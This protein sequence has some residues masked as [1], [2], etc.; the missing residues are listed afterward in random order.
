MT[1]KVL[2]P[3]CGEE[4]QIQGPFFH[5]KNYSGFFHCESCGWESPTG[6]GDTKKEAEENARQAALR[7]Y[8]PP[9]RPMTLEE[10]EADSY[11][12]PCW[13]EDVIY[14]PLFPEVLDKDSTGYFGKIDAANHKMV[15]Y[16]MPKEYGKT[17]RCW[18]RRPTDEEREA[19]G[20]EDAE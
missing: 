4:M 20:W 2:C 7:R 14:R 5:R 10:L 12:Y 17:W 8:E 6:F 19:A 18:P 3:G 13:I 9:I 1:D 15:D 11:C 16:F